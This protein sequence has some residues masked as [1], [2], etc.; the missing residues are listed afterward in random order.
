MSNPVTV[1]DLEERFRPLTEQE[2]TNAQGML[3]DAWELLLIRVPS[4][5]SRLANGS[6]SEGSIRYVLREALIPVLRNPDGY[7]RWSIDDATFER[8]TS[9]ADGRLT[10]A[11]DLLALLMPGA[12]TRRG[13][14][15]VTPGPVTT[16]APGSESEY[17]EYLRSGSPYGTYRVP[18]GSWP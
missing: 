6:L 5:E 12:A 14:F 13:A 10:I 2:Q 16:T 7:K 17:I 4:L 3:D 8:D 9:V 1:A 15:S 11:D 18:P